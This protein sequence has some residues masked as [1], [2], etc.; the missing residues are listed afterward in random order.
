MHQSIL[1]ANIPLGN[2]GILHLLSARVPGLNCPSELS[3]LLSIIKV[4]S[5][6]MMPHQG[7]FQLQIDLPS[8]AVLCSRHGIS[9]AEP[10]NCIIDKV[11][12][13]EFDF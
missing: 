7:T 9:C 6:Q 4:P 2:P 8:I 3:D 1:S 5:C 10:G 12:C 13:I 11:Q